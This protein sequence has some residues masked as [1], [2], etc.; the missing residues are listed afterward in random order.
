MAVYMLTKESGDSDVG[1]IME[2]ST[3]L[4]H[5][6]DFSRVSY[7]VGRTN[8]CLRSEVTQ[9][10]EIHLCG[11]PKGAAGSGCWKPLS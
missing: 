2:G 3:V 8:I 11:I 10:S 6:D 9:T 4:H 5:L 1:I 7:H